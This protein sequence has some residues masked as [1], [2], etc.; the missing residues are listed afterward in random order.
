MGAAIDRV[1]N[2]HIGF[3]QANASRRLQPLHHSS[4]NG[5][6]PLAMGWVTPG[7]GHASPI[8]PVFDRER[9][10]MQW[11][12]KMALLALLKI[13]ARDGLG[14]IMGAMATGVLG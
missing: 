1:V 10:P 6:Y 4:V 3:A 9:N 13:N 7:T 14:S 2:H 8:N 11:P 12:Q 5:R